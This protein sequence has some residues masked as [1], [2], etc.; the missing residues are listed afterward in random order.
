MPCHHYRNHILNQKNTLYRSL[1][2][3]ALLFLFILL[4]NTPHRKFDKIKESQSNFSNINHV[5]PETDFSKLV[6]E[7]RKVL[8]ENRDEFLDELLKELNFTEVDL[9]SISRRDD[10]ESDRSIQIYL[11]KIV[12]GLGENATEAKVPPEKVEEA[13][14]VLQEQYLNKILS[15]MIAF[16]RSLPDFR[17]PE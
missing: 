17:E 5:S 12:P 13:E 4:I 1:P 7:R 14:R 3:F 2:I 6:K 8:V 9:I 10:P 16:N 11:N 15:D